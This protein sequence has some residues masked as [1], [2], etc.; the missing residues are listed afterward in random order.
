MNVMM[1]IETIVVYVCYYSRHMLVGDSQNGQYKWIEQFRTIHLAHFGVT[2][3]S[4]M[5]DIILA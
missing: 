4:E 2:Q 3:Y 1:I 5:C